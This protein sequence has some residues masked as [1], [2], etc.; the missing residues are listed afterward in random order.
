[1]VC[2]RLVRESPTWKGFVVLFV[3]DA[4]DAAAHSAARLPG[5]LARPRESYND[6]TRDLKGGLVIQ[7]FVDFVNVGGASRF[8]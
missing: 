1:M 3:V 6:D 7:R 8:R 2:S 4:E 5:Y